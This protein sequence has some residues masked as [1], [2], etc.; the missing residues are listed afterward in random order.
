MAVF[1]GE[2][3]QLLTGPYWEEITKELGVAPLGY[4]PKRQRAIWPVAEI[5]HRYKV[6]R[7]VAERLRRLNPEGVEEGCYPRG[8][9]RRWPLHLAMDAIT[10]AEFRRRFGREA[11]KRLPPGAIWK[12]RG[13][14]RRKVVSQQAIRNMV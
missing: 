13:A 7:H 9:H 5:I 3:L 14:G 11:E 2:M 6:T 12:P 4:S 10:L 8:W 1:A